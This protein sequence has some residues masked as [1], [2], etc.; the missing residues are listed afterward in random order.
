MSPGLRG[1]PVKLDDT[2]GK[3]EALS[4]CGSPAAAHSLYG[5]GDG[6]VLVG[7]VCNEIYEVDF[8]SAEPPMCYMQGHHDEVWGLATHPSKLEVA[9]AAEDN[10]LRVWELSTRTMKG[11]ARLPGPGRCVAYS[12]DGTLIAVG[13]GCG[14]KAKG[15]SATSHDGKWLVLEAEN[16]N[17]VAA[18]PHIRSQRISDIKWSPDSKWVAVGCADNHIDLY[19]WGGGGSFEHKGILRGHSSFIR[20]IDWAEDSSALQSCCGAHELLYWRLYSPEGKLRPAQEK[21]SSSMKDVRF[22][23]FSCIFGWPV[24][25]IWPED[26]DGTDVNACARS[27]V[28]S[29]DEGLL[30][31]GDDFGKVKLFRWP[32]IVPRAQHR[33]YGGHSSHVTHVAFTHQVLPISHH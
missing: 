11:M 31:T 5:D 17:Q 16:L 19:S 1:L 32:C 6:R 3:E 4:K 27:H 7:T 24:R 23:T 26:S 14:G 8:D 2:S 13:L 9:T 28:S 22:H 15:R 12:P 25:G 29:R 20:A 33:P 30:A 10:T 21:T 18:P